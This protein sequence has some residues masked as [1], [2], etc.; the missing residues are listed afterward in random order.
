[1]EI[2]YSQ[3]WSIHRESIVPA[4]LID[5]GTGKPVTAQLPNPGTAVGAFQRRP[6]LDV[7]DF[8]VGTFLLF[9]AG[10]GGDVVMHHV[11][12]RGSAAARVG[13]ND[14]CKSC[15]VWR[16][17]VAILGFSRW[18]ALIYVTCFQASS[19]FGTHSVLIDVIG[20][21]HGSKHK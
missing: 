1:M 19:P 10:N 18:Y 15:G 16:K 7:H 4:S 8:R 17:L 11:S 14:W 13:C 3:R 5:K 12:K 6:R 2:K 9:G 21:F 20:F